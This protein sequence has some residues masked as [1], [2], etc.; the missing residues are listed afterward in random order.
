MRTTTPRRNSVLPRSVHHI[1]RIVPGPVTSAR[2]TV[3]PALIA[4]DGAPL[5]PSL[6]LP[7]WPLM[8]PGFSNEYHLVSTPG[9]RSYRFF[10]GARTGKASRNSRVV[11][12]RRVMCISSLPT[13]EVAGALLP[14]IGTLVAAPFQ[15]QLAA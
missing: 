1:L 7:P 4:R 13:C 10:E 14:L 9:G 8:P 15:A 11:D 2:T 3:S 5:R 12:I 6:A